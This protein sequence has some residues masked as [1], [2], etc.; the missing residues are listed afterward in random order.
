MVDRLY[1]NCGRAGSPDTTV[2]NPL[3]AGGGDN[4]MF[5]GGQSGWV[6]KAGTYISPDGPPDGHGF[7]KTL[8]GSTTYL[9]SAWEPLGPRSGF[10][11]W[12]YIPGPVTADWNFIRLVNAAEQA[13]GNLYLR[14]NGT[15]RAY[16]G[17]SSISAS[18]SPNIASEP[19]WYCFVVMINWEESTFEYIIYR[20]NGTIFHEWHNEDTSTVVTFPTGPVAG[21]RVGDIIASTS[22]GLT[23]MRVGSRIAWGDLETGWIPGDV[24]P[25]TEP[26]DPPP[27][28][29]PVT[30]F[31]TAE[32]LVDG[33]TVPV[34]TGKGAYGHDFA[35]RLGSA[36]S[37][38]KGTVD[39]IWGTRAV[40]VQA[41]P[42]QSAYLRWGISGKSCAF[43]MYLD[44]DEAPSQSTQVVKISNGLDEN[45]GRLALTSSSQLIVQ[46]SSDGVDTTTNLGTIL[47]PAILRLEIWV[48]VNNDTVHA[49]WGYK[50]GPR[51]NQGT[52]FRDLKDSELLSID[53]GKLHAT[54]WDCDIVMDDFA[55]NERA[56]SLI[57]AHSEEYI[58]Y[59]T[60][61][62][63]DLTNIEPGTLVTLQAS[64]NGDEAWTQLSGP[65]VLLTQLGETA[66]FVAPYTVDG[67]TLGFR[68]GNE[69]VSVDQEV[70]VLRA[71]EKMMWGGS[72]RPY[73]VL[74][75]PW[76]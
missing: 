52:A 39:A 20:E 44:I 75:G 3:L 62:P 30:K 21:A 16:Q 61:G 26:P 63:Q 33:V 67:A 29:T 32:N 46:T 27:A 48:D 6:Y 12:V 18:Q 76:N 24:E 9:R 36:A 68:F 69:V 37:N 55:A 65:E 8:T 71:T 38:V 11:V 15:I 7:H 13:V 14:T 41:G 19:G 22:H 72:I 42:G 64:G 35:S 25:Y 50:D 73:K 4:P 1:A 31:N 51:E 74:T 34:G 45:A 57:G 23:E 5:I 58:L 54:D 60:I 40:R 66:T 53:F 56:T 43:R 59:P 70:S 49:A 10:R 17:S 47:Y 28:T 2:T